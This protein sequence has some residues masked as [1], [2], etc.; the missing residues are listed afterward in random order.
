MSDRITFKITTEAP[1]WSSDQSAALRQF[2]NTASGQAFLQ[3]LFW[4]RPGVTPPSSMLP[5][6]AARRTAE[7]DILCG[8]ELAIREILNHTNPN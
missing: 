6:D 5:G 2:L 8:Y 1:E 4:F 7:A 3:R